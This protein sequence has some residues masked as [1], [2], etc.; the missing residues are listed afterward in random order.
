MGGYSVF[1]VWCVI[2]IFTNIFN[3]KLKYDKRRERV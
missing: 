3:N 2:Y 1:N